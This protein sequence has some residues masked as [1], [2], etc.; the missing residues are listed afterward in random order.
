MDSF[1]ISIAIAII[2]SVTLIASII[3]IIDTYGMIK[4]IYFLE[5]TLPT[6]IKTLYKNNQLIYKDVEKLIEHKARNEM[7]QEDGKSIINKLYCRV[8]TNNKNIA[9]LFVMDKLNNAHIAKLYL[10]ELT[11]IV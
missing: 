3:I 8:Q 11:K 1:Q 6:H 10:N 2:C 5:N 4:R 7:E 9:T